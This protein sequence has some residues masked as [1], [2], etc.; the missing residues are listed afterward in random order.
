[1][2]DELKSMIEAIGGMAELAF[3]HYSRF[4]GA[5]FSAEQSFELTKQFMSYMYAPML[6]NKMKEDIEEDDSGRDPG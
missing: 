3:I 1:M 2:N 6:L 4:L 5:G